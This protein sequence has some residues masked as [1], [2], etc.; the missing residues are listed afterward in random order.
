MS[1]THK[2]VRTAIVGVFVLRQDEKIAL[3]ATKT[4]TDTRLTAL[5]GGAAGLGGVNAAANPALPNGEI[6]D[7][8]RSITDLL[9]GGP[10]G[11][12]GYAGITPT[13]TSFTKTSIAVVGA[14]TATQNVRGTDFLPFPLVKLVPASGSQIDVSDSVVMISSSEFTLTIPTTAVGT[15]GVVYQ[16]SVKNPLDTT[17]ST[18]TS[19]ATFTFTRT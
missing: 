15:N 13:I 3:A 1:Q 18:V 14:I 19:V 11:D 4:T 7:V 17:T 5:G 8:V 12:P 9:D 2:D 6:G 16:V 10:G